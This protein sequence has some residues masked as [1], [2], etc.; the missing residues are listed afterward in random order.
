MKPLLIG[1]NKSKPDE[2]AL[3]PM[4]D[5]CAGSRL[6][7]LLAAR[8]GATMREYLH[9]F[10]RRSLVIGTAYQRLSARAKAHE[11]WMELQQSGRTVILLGRDVVET[12]DWVIR[13]DGKAQYYIGA[14]GGTVRGLP[15]VLVHP[16]VI[17]G[18]TFRQVPLPIRTNPWY[19][20]ESNRN[21]IELLMEELYVNAGGKVQA[22]A[23]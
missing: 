23:M 16:Q 5:G 17:G 1:M 6:W 14:D 12:F 11:Y 8:T 21:V 10:E 4:P 18:V 15:P 22:Q 20:V 9:H 3:Y 19:Q 13:N 2:E 7:R